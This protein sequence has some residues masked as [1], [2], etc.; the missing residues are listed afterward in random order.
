MTDILTF[1]TACR[2]YDDEYKG[3]SRQY[4]QGR[5]TYLLDDEK[6]TAWIKRGYIGRCKR[7]RVPDHVMVGEERYTVESIEI[8]AFNAPKTLR[9]RVC[10]SEVGICWQRSAV[11]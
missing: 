3:P 10:K 8:G 5:F 7:Y 11:Y 9:F 4:Q 2:F 6:K 1:E